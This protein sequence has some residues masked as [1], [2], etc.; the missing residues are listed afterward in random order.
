MCT[1]T[2]MR[3]G[4]I[5]AALH[6]RLIVEHQGEPDTRFLDE[7]SLCG[8]VRVDVAVINGTLAGYEL[9]SDL[10]TLRRLPAQVA[11]Y[12]KVL[13]RATL[14]VGERHRDHAV[15]VLPAWWGVIVAKR[16]AG[17]VIL[18]DDRP[19][20]W[21]DEVDAYAVAQL[22]WREEALAILT[23]RGLDRGVRSKPRQ[24]L[25]QRLAEEVSVSQLRAAVRQKLKD[26]AGWRVP[27]VRG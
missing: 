21:N 9:K 24:M 13:D 6:A 5:R 18:G 11:V 2:R 4:E 12:S 15:A 26:R 16:A 19:G 14:V 8:L 27:I 20:R 25:W 1:V 3:D 7:L 23:D 22:L 10:D 17:V